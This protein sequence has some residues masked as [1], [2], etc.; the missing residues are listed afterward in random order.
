MSHDQG[1]ASSAAFRAYVQRFDLTILGVALATKVR[2]LTVWKIE[3][4]LPIR[5]A[6]ALAVRTG[7]QQVTG[8]PYPA[9]ICVI[10]ADMPWMGKGRKPG[11]SD[12]PGERE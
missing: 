11:G 9:L 12:E 7:L 1:A 2:L 8:V 5:A 6:D 4:G 3:Q 10:P